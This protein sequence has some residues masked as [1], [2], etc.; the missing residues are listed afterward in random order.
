MM[1]RRIAQS[2]WMPRIM[3]GLFILT[4]L[5]SGLTDIHAIREA[6]AAGYQDGL[7]AA[8]SASTARVKCVRYPVPPLPS[9]C[10]AGSSGPATFQAT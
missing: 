10:P 3:V 9:S 1:L 2:K 7:A 6:K 8:A 4:V 5:V